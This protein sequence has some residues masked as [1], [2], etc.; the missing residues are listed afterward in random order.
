MQV[1]E[2]YKKSTQK[3]ACKLVDMFHLAF[4]FFTKW[5]PCFTLVALVDFHFIA[6][7]VVLIIVYLD[8]TFYVENSTP[9]FC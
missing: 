3:K 2:L 4:T 5:Q 1:G 9:L 8:L 6:L 7:N